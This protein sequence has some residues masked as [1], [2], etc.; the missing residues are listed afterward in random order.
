[1]TE[2]QKTISWKFPKE[3]WIA[4]VMELFERA[5]YYGFFIVLTLYLTDIVGFND[6]ETGVVAGIFY[7]LLYLLPP[8]AGAV[9]D[10]IGFKNGLILAFGLLTIGYTLLGLYHEKVFVIYLIFTISC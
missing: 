4:N 9:S 1:M 6:K 3:F 5:A 7:A 8:F 2:N 10:K